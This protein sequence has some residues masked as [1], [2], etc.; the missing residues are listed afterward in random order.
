[1]EANVIVQWRR[2]RDHALGEIARMRREVWPTMS[3]AE[4]AHFDKEA[5]DVEQALADTE[6]AMRARCASIN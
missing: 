6:A 2:W 3:P 1:M 4:Q 5:A